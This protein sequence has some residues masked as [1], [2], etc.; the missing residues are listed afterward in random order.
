[1]D[2]LAG[3]GDREAIVV[4]PF[5]NLIRLS[6]LPTSDDALVDFCVWR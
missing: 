5:H 1:M 3:V 4:L 6:A 2:R